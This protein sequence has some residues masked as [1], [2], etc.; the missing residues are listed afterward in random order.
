M[1]SLSVKLGVILVVIGLAIFSCAEVRGEDWKL[2]K[3]T[4]DANFYYD[5]RGISGSPQKIVSVWIKQVYTKKGKMDMMNLVGPRYENLGYSINSL[6]FDCGAKKVRFLSMT[7]Y[8][9][10]GGVLD[11]E[12]PS[13]QW[14]SI[15]SNS[16]FDALFRK[17]CE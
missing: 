9:K 1:K 16:I 2:F 17:V 8:S 13:D 10:K 15:P 4:E 11:L 5:T 6:E 12:N 3:K 7:Y 14:E